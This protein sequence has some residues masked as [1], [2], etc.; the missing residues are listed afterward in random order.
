MLAN[1]QH[2]V[3]LWLTEKTG[4]TAG[5]FI[6]G[7]I[8]VVAALTGFIFLCVSG[9]D[10]AAAQLGPVFGGLASAGVFLAIAVCGFAVSVSSRNRA[11]RGAALERARRTQGASLLIN[12]KTL[13]VVMRAG[14]YRLAKAYSD[15]ANGLSRNPVGSRATP[16]RK[17]LMIQPDDRSSTRRK[18]RHG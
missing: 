18:H 3:R 17:Y 6:F 12:P 15:R 13:Q 8:A 14:R 16:Q 11:R 7:G 2:K 5:F 1:L 9:Y 10:W 4:L